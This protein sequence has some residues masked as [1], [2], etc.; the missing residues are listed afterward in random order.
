MTQLEQL[1]QE[2]EIIKRNI[3]RV[4][5]FIKDNQNNEYRPYSS[6]VFGE[7][8]HRLTALKGTIT[9]ITKMSTNNLF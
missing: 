5:Q 9:A 1:K 3:K 6:N 2:L 4:E 8:K 7:L